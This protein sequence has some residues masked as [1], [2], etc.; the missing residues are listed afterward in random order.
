MR[1]LWL[2]LKSSF[3]PEVSWMTYNVT[4]GFKQCLGWG[5]FIGGGLNSS[6]CLTAAGKCEILALS[7][8]RDDVTTNRTEPCTNTN[9]HEPHTL[10]LPRISQ[11]LVVFIFFLQLL[12]TKC[13][14]RKE[15]AA[16]PPP[17]ACSEC[18]PRSA[19][20]SLSAPSQRGP[21]G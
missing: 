18:G 6:W 11:V 16:P 4:P 13:I 20:P 19:F 3:V 17:P 8:T 21:S 7:S 14:R 15:R 12:C 9:S 1:H 2:T 5:C 10:T